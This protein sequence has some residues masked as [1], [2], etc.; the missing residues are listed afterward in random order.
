MTLPSTVRE[1]EEKIK[2]LQNEKDTICGYTLQQVTRMINTSD[3]LSEDQ[4]YLLVK[5][6][7][8]SRD[9]NGRYVNNNSL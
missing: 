8:R 6:V 7:W 3:I 1:L 4:K 2:T 9:S 5:E